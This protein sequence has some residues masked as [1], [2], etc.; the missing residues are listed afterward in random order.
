MR[1]AHDYQ[2]LITT[3]ITGLVLDHAALTPLKELQ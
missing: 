2:R 3:G 1:D